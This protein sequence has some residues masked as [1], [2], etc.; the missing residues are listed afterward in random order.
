MIVFRGV[1][2]F[3][4]NFVFWVLRVIKGQKTVLNGKKF[5][6]SCSISQEPYMIWLS[7]KVYMCKMVISSGTFFIFA[8]FCFFWVVKMQK[9]KKKNSPK[10]QKILSIVLYISG[11]IP[12]MIVIYGTLVW[13][14]NTSRQFSYFW[15]ILIFW[16]VRGVK[17]QK[18]FQNDKKFH[19]LY[20]ISQ[21]PYMIWLSFMVYVCKMIISPGMFFIF[22]KFWFFDL[23]SVKK[24][25]NGPKWQN[26]VCCPLHLRNH[27]SY[28]DCDLWCTCVKW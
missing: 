20:S 23:L 15:K 28:Y 18:M 5:C 26:Y 7:F 2:L 10:W 13:N 9:G 19:L 6:R 27:T 8:K 14:D 17:W 3:L 16:V 12:S 21:E 25:K 22:A 1:F 4:W 11:T 24:G